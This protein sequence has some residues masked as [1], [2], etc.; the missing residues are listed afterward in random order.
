ME[1]LRKSQITGK[2]TSPVPHLPRWYIVSF[3]NKARILRLKSEI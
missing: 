2:I 3:R 1:E